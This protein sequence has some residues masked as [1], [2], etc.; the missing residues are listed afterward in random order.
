[1]IVTAYDMYFEIK[2][3]CEGK[4]TKIESQIKKKQKSKKKKIG[5]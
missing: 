5:K 3:S 4:I 2:E 1:V